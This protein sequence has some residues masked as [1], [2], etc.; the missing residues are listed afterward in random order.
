MNDTDVAV[1][2]E[3]ESLPNEIVH[4]SYRNLSASQ[5]ALLWQRH[6]SNV[7]DNWDLT[8]EQKNHIAKLQNL[9][10]K[11]LFSRVGTKELQDQM[12][13]FVKEWYDPAIASGLFTQINLVKISTIKG[14]GNGN[15][16]GR[17]LVGDCVCYYS[18]SCGLLS[19]IDNKTC[20]EGLENPFDC[21]ILGTSRCTG[22]CE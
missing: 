11:T 2:K 20:S 14:I 5:K 1:V 19:C 4:I 16:S 9:V 15:Y 3:L 7:M 13:S 12:D 22:K 17:V 21:G 8:T 10:S 18:L 6:L